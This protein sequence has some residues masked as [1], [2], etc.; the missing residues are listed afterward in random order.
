MGVTED[1]DMKE[2]G[3]GL[4]TAQE[5]L[6]LSLPDSTNNNSCLFRWRSLSRILQGPVRGVWLHSRSGKPDENPESPI[7]LT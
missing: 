2:A 7:P 6:S 5:T 4:E 3:K 1:R